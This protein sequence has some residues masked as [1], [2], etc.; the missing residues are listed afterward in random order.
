M[1]E[2][3]QLVTLKSHWLRS[4]EHPIDMGDLPSKV[5]IGDPLQVIKKVCDTTPNDYYVVADKQGVQ[6]YVPADC[7]E[8]YPPS[9][10]TLYKVRYMLPGNVRGFCGAVGLKITRYYLTMLPN[11][12]KS[13]DIDIYISKSIP[14]CLKY[15]T[16]ICSSRP[17][18][19][20][21]RLLLKQHNIPYN[22]W[23][24]ADSLN[25]FKGPAI[26]ISKDIRLDKTQSEQNLSDISY[27]ASTLGY[28]RT[29]NKDTTKHINSY[30]Y[31]EEDP[32]SHFLDYSAV[33]G[34]HT[35]LNASWSRGEGESNYMC[36]AALGNTINALS[37]IPHTPTELHDGVKII[38]L[39]SMKNSSEMGLPSEAFFVY[40]GN[41]TLH[42][43][44][45]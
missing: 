32:L 35:L 40:R 23:Y 11:P 34:V 17:V 14:L 19:D 25:R 30:K 9:H 36:G 31:I 8:V 7:L 41:Y 1:L 22:Y 26:I 12:I 44:E 21:T 42:Q 28:S 2:Q 15:K 16:L 20:T 4:Q 18:F 5:A 45:G 6:W 24:M 10:T 27:T 43:G 39:A 38:W 3:G 29:G 33:K 13:P 37:Q